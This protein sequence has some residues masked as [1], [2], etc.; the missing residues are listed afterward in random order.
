M[1]IAIRQILINKLPDADA[2]INE[3]EKHIQTYKLRI[4]TLYGDDISISSQDYF[5]MAEEADD[6]LQSLHHDDTHTIEH[7]A[8]EVNRMLETAARMEHYEVLQKMLEK[9]LDEQNKSKEIQDAN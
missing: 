9:K 2:T 7:F 1:T 4:E 8:R 5:K 6:I 3:I